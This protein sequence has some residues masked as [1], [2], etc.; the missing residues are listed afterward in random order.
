MSAGVQ[1]LQS[2]E[3]NL[4]QMR[5]EEQASTSPILRYVFMTALVLVVGGMGWMYIS[6][7]LEIKR[8]MRHWSKLTFK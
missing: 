6:S 2:I 1:K 5:H 8:R 7:K 4:L 3:I